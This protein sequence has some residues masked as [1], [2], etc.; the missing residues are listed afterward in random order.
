MCLKDTVLAHKSM[1]DLKDPLWV[2]CLLKPCKEMVIPDEL[3]TGRGDWARVGPHLTL[4]RESEVVGVAKVEVAGEI[5][6]LKHLQ[7]SGEMSVNH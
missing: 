3:A 7:I 4:E 2:D 1:D 6:V 5:Q